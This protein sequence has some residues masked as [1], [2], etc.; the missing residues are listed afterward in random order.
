VTAFTPCSIAHF[1]AAGT[2]ER[3]A[4]ALA[5]ARTQLRDDAYTEL[6]RRGAAMSYAQAMSYA[7]SQLKDLAVAAPLTAQEP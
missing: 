2:S 5:P 7:R 1:G 6:Y 3:I 4:R